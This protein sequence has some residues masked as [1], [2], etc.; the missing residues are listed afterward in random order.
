MGSVKGNTQTRGVF[1]YC[2]RANGV[3]KNPASSKACE[4]ANVASLVLKITGTIGDC[5][6]G[7]PSFSQNKAA[8]CVGVSQ[9]A[10]IAFNEVRAAMAAARSLVAS[11]W[12]KPDCGRGCV[13][14]TNR[15]AGANIAAIPPTALDKVPIC[16][17]T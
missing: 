14:L 11:Q 5:G 13:K 2:W 3:T 4:A 10:G 1:W 9:S 15:M 17:S 7:K 8:S 6:A 16:K 12:K